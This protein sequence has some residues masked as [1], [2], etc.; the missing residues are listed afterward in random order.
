MQK[1]IPKKLF[2]LTALFLCG[3]FLQLLLYIPPTTLAQTPNTNTCSNITDPLTPDE[4]TYARAAWQYFV[5]NYQPTTGFT[6]STGGYPSGTLWDMGNYLM[7]LNAARWLNLIDQPDFDSRLNKFLTSLN[8]LKLFEDALPNKVYN[9]ATGE[10]VDYGNNLVEKGIGWSALDIGRILAAF[11]VIRTCHPQYNEWLQG[12]VTKW[13]VGRSLKDNQIFGAMVL[14]DKN[15]LLVQE[16]RLGYEE[17]AVRG[18]ELWG[19]KA[20]KAVALEPFKFV[21]INGVQIPVDTR[22]FQS[23]NAN[24][25]VVSESYIL[26]GIEFG[27]VGYLQ[28]FATRVLE[29]QKRRFEATGQLTA[30]SEDNID[31][32]PYFLYN[33]VY[34][35]GVPWATIT[36]E[37]KLYPQFRTFSSKAAFGW[38]YLFPNNAYAQKLFDAA[39]DLRSPDGGGFY[40]GIYEENQQP[41]KALTG[42]TNGLIMEI[43]YYKARGNRPLIGGNNVS[44]ANF[45]SSPSVATPATPPTT[46]PVTPPASPVVVTVAPI[47]PVGNPQPSSCPALTQPLTGVQRRY[48]EAAW[49]YFIANYQSTT[50]LVSDRKDVKGA[51]VWGL[52]N[53][54]AALHAARTLDVISAK[55]FDQRTRQLLGAL[56]Q[57]PLF[58]GELPHRGYDTRTLQAIDYGGNPTSEG[59]GWSALDVGRILATLHNLKTCHPEYTTAVDQIVLDWSYLR[60]VN[61]GTLASATIV[62]DKHGRSLPRVKPE[63]R[64]GYEEYASRAFQLWGFD[65]NRSAVGGEYQTAKVEGVAVPI[66]RVRTDSNSQ[67]SQYT[68][69][70]P[71]LLYGLEFGLDPQMRSLFT[72]IFQAQAERYRHTKTL[73]AAGTT[74]IEQQPYTVHSTITSQNQ[75]WLALG[76]DSKPFAEG[77]LVSTAVAFAYHAMLPGDNYAQELF[78]ATTDLYRPLLGF[79]EGFYEKTGKTALGFSSSTNSMVLE[80]L[81]YMATKQQP[82]IRPTSNMKSP[83]WQ[84]VNAGDSGR[85]LPSTTNQKSRFISDKSQNY[86]VSGTTK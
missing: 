80:S 39:K 76:D 11:H 18:Y 85:G 64:L 71:F 86:W 41:N 55:E 25:Y 19:F 54:L 5:N 65:A 49:A 12:I 74:L 34:S 3:T 67:T 7:A 51:T 68:V 61:H 73:T 27:L 43:L 32:A 70:N 16:G 36:E 52:G 17:Y 42:N 46:T 23:T 31:Q 78:K 4:Q 30:V 58:M 60:V 84:A 20:P 29:V 33:T 83:W 22:D 44:F 45:N 50:G 69:S 81:L 62:K 59:T 66:Q 40:A 9:T 38:R 21:D 72:N 1:N 53:Y 14:P 35:N 63:T 37:N 6:N 77:R 82:L 75:P 24:N 48:A 8:N 10:M 57:M 15:T 2:Q 13:Q 56:T 26:D 47:P 28:D 79:Y